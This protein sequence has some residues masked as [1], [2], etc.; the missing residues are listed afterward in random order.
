MQPATPPRQDDQELPPTLQWWP[1]TASTSEEVLLSPP[2]MM[3]PPFSPFSAFSKQPPMLTPSQFLQPFLN[4]SM[5]PGSQ[6]QNEPQ[7]SVPQPSPVSTSYLSPFALAQPLPGVFSPPPSNPHSSPSPTN[8]LRNSPYP[9]VAQP[10]GVLKRNSFLKLPPEVRAAIYKEL[11]PEAPLHV[12]MDS[13]SGKMFSYPC[14]QIGDAEYV[15]RHW[16]AMP[17]PEYRKLAST[18]RECGHLACIQMGPRMRGLGRDERGLVA[19]LMTCR[20][21]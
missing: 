5:P 4:V 8:S 21:V 7:L 13:I 19:L 15:G 3:S 6:A 12:T 20:A 18:P 17:E 9:F 11:V 1:P 10:T 14:Q 2:D 16:F